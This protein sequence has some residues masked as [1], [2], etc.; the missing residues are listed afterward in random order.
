MDDGSDGAST[1]QRLASCTATDFKFLGM[2]SI[3]TNARFPYKSL[4]R[5][6]GHCIC[7]NVAHPPAG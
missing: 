1:H 7:V 4:N 5:R 2:P 3:Q 6:L